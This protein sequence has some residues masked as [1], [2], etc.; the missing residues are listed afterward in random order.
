MSIEID[1]E[2]NEVRA[3]E[4]VTN[5]MKKRVLE[6]GCGDGRLSQRLASLGAFVQA[7]D[8]DPTLIHKARKNLPQRFANSVL[9]DVGNAER[10]DHP[11]ASFDVVV[12]SWSL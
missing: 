4:S 5:W 7:R 11:N 8:P 10:I 2:Q 12:F 3:L 1:P 6:V 9:Y